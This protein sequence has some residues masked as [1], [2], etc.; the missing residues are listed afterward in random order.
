SKS[1][2]AG[3]DLA[4]Y[5]GVCLQLGGYSDVRIVG[6]D[7]AKQTPRSSN[8][9]DG[10]ADD[11]GGVP[12]QQRQQRKQSGR[13]LVVPYAGDKPKYPNHAEC[14]R[15]TWESL[16]K[17]N[18]ILICVDPADTSAC[19]LALSSAVERGSD[20]AIISFD[21]GIKNHMAVE[22]RLGNHNLVFLGGAVG[23]SVARSPVDGHLRCLGG[24]SL[25]LERLTKQQS[26]RGVKF[27]NLLRSGGIPVLHCKN[28]RSYTHGVV[29][30]NTVHAAAALA[31]GPL[32]DLVRDRHARLLWAAM[33]REGL[34]A[35]TLAA[36]GGDW[37]AAN[38]CCGVTLPQLELLLCLPT[39]LFSLV[40]RLL[41]RFPP[42]LAP[43]MQAD[44]ADGRETSVAWTLEEIVRIADKHK[45]STPACRAVLSAVKRCVSGGDGVPS[46]R[47][48]DLPFVSELLS[49]GS[50]SSRELNRKVRVVVSRLF[51]EFLVGHSLL[52]PVCFSS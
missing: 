48:R 45:G 36:R 7:G 9:A 41:L 40:S 26:K 27:V 24:G 14:F 15:D 1:T 50:D 31:G 2:S 42:M 20:K 43:A 39:F 29:I 25:V 5:L 3:E 33:I 35:L 34:Q 23:I 12:P 13:F 38:P 16:S 32:R 11:V 46:T 52:V 4:I 22:E 30:F 47:P 28:V 19:A 10:D 8:K 17:C 21:L 51:C 6:F 44:L 37:R 49:G 18:V